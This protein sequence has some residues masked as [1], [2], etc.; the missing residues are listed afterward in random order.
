MFDWLAK[1]G[2]LNPSRVDPELRARS[3]SPWFTDLAPQIIGTNSAEPPAPPV[4]PD[5]QL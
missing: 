5:D 3:S 2:S 1:S 4:G